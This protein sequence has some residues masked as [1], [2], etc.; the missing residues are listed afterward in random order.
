LSLTVLHVILHIGY[1]ALLHYVHC[2]MSTRLPS[3]GGAVHGSE[4]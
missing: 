2:Q 4:L 3:T 1:R